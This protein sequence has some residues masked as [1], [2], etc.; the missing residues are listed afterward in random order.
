MLDRLL[1][2][3]DSNNT[4]KW[5][6]VRALVVTPTRE[7]AEQVANSVRTYGR[8]TGIRSTAVYGGVGYGPQ[9]NAFR[10]GID[11]VIATPGRLLDHIN[12]G[13]LDLSKVEILVLDEADRMFDMGFE[14]DVRKIVAAIKSTE[15][16][17]L[18]FS[19]TM[20]PAIQKLAASIQKNPTLI[21]IGERTNAAET[22]TQRFYRVAQTQKND[23]LLHV[24]ENEDVT[25]VLV[26]SRTRHRANRISKR[27]QKQGIKSAPIHSDR[28]QGQRQRALSDFKKGKVKVLVATDIA[29]RGIDVEGISHVIN[30]DTPNQAEDYIHRIGR[31]GRAEN[32]GLALTFV[33]PDEVPYARTISKVTGNRISR[34][35]YP[36]FNHDDATVSESAEVAPDRKKSHS[37]HPHW[38][39][40]G[41]GYKGKKRWNKR[42]AGRRK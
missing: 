35:L 21:E 42:P 29:A 15:R 36:Q 16:Q 10:R 37:G 25:S 3:S 34:E 33:S 38:K 6:P 23:L 14:K 9:I 8:F 18:L 11:I 22:V 32:E 7:L 30:F 12:N 4:K 26:F 2:A 39:K 13:K 20:P 17:T 41:G 31:T 24:L 5:R 28:T 1:H 19:A 27:L 40:K